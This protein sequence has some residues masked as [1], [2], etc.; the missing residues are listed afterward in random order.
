MHN[1]RVFLIHSSHSWKALI[2]CCLYPVTFDKIQKCRVTLLNIWINSSFY[3]ILR[4]VFLQ[5]IQKLSCFWS[6]FTGKEISWFFKSKTMEIS[7]IFRIDCV[8]QGS[9]Y[10]CVKDIFYTVRFCFNMSHA[11]SETCRRQNG[12]LKSSQPIIQTFSLMHKQQSLYRLP[13]HKLP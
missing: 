6:S 11:L 9:W 12:C 5:S 13:W 2:I 1:F 3:V 8:Y 4:F 10:Q 7:S